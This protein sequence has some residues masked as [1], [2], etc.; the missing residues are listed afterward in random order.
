MVVSFLSLTAI[1]LILYTHQGRPLPNW[2]Y[3]MTINSMIAV[4]STIMKSAILLLT[5]ECISQSKWIW[6][7]TDG[8]VLADIEIFDMASRGPWGSAHMLS[9]I[10]WK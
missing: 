5:V 8:H 7:R 6:F 1:I 4:F 10:R 9:R 3:S 2:P